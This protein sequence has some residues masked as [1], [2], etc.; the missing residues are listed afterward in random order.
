MQPSESE[1]SNADPIKTLLFGE[2]IGPVR[3]L[4]GYKKHHFVPDNHSDATQA[5]VRSV[6]SEKIKD[7]ADTLFLTIRHHFELKRKQINYTCEDGYGYLATPDFTAELFI[8]QD[9]DN[10]AQYLETIQISQLHNEAIAQ[11]PRLHACFD[12]HCDTLKI[13]FLGPINVEEKIDAI[14]DIPQLEQYLSYAPDGSFLDLKMREISLHLHIDSHS[15]SFKLIGT[16]DLATLLTRSQ[17]TLNLL[18]PAGFP[19]RIHT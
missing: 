2:S 5:F 7:L 18:A 9:P 13:E 1:F 19:K 16:R 10:P 12:P 14:E 6:G 17:E 11:D 15:A 8:D 3:K 4:A